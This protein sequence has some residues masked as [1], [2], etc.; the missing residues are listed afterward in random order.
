MKKTVY[1]AL[2]LL[3]L[4][5]V[6]VTAFVS[7]GKEEQTPKTA[8]TITV[9]TAGGMPL[10]DVRVTVYKNSAR[11]GMVWAA[12][13]DENGSTAFTA[14]HSDDYIA[15]LE[16]V[17]LG[18]TVQESY[19]VAA[20]QTDIT[21]T[22]SLPDGA[23]LSAYT[24][25]LGDILCDFTVS[26][27]YMSDGD[28]T[29]STMDTYTLSALLEE[30]KAVVLN[31]WFLNCGPCRMEFPYLQEAYE[32]YTEELEVL[33]INPVDGT[34]PSIVTYASEMGLTFPMVVG[35]T[36]WES[37]MQL[38]AYPTTVVIDRYGMI[39]MIHKGYITE[40]A[41]FEAIFEYFTSDDYV[42]TTVKSIEDLT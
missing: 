37:A 20:Q 6:T 17:P 39:A 14:A 4:V 26:A 1:K 12:D 29:S 21:L 24:F 8:H 36:A 31:F 33:A 5:C 25:S 32:A 38:T 18:Y 9:H 16:G 30:K 19:P 35:D 15:V 3:L 22:A 41:T 13:T 7:C 28:A 10:A 2:A 34:V 40:T 42:Q 27:G 11:E 23:D